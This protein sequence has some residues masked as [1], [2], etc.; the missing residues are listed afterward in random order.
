MFEQIKIMLAG[1][2]TEPLPTV[3]GLLIVAVSYLC[4]DI[5]D[6]RSRWDKRESD[7]RIE[8]VEREKK[9]AEQ[10]IDLMNFYRVKLDSIAER[11]LRKSDK[12]LKEMNT[13]I[14]QLNKR[15]R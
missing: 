10:R 13:V 3:C 8:S 6:T 12:Q 4:M 11:E 2:K 14:E 15:E 7:Y 9:C 1:L 5:R